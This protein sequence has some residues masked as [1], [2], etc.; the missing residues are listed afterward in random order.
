ML[1]ET[2]ELLVAKHG[3]T[4]DE[5]QAYI[6]KTLKRISNPDLPDTCERVGRSPLRK[7]S[8]HE[9]FIGPAAEL[10][11]R[12]HDAWDLLNAVGAALRFDVAEDAESVE[13]QALLASGGTAPPRSRRRSRG[14]SRRIRCSRTWSR[15]SNCDWPVSDAIDDDDEEASLGGRRG[16]RPEGARLPRQEGPGSMAG[17]PRTSRI[18]ASPA[19][20]RVR[21]CRRR[22]V[23]VGV[24]YLALH[25]RLDPRGA[26]HRIRDTTCSPRCSGSSA[27][28]SRSRRAALVRRRRSA[29][30]RRPAVVRAGGWCSAP[31]RRAVAVS[32]LAAVTNESRRHPE[33]STVRPPAAL[34]IAL[35]AVLFAVLTLHP[36]EAVSNPSRCRRV[37]EALGIGDPSR[38]GCSIVGVVPPV[39]MFVRRSCSGGGRSA[40]APR[41]AARRVARAPTNALA[42]SV[43]ALVLCC[44]RAARSAG[45]SSDARLTASITSA[46]SASCARPRPER[47][48]GAA[49]PL[50]MPRR[51][52][53]PGT[54]RSGTPRGPPPRPSAPFHRAAAT[55]DRPTPRELADTRE[56]TS[57]GDGN[58]G[59][60]SAG[61]IIA[62]MR[63]DLRHEVGSP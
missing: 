20:D 37:Y 53:S 24:V 16:R 17:R 30:P 43:A 5:Q 21:S 38:G 9:R 58:P 45:C 52:R 40:R 35:V 62:R 33:P 34:S 51:T 8:R 41:A 61:G 15:S 23:L 14:S 19:R 59:R 26:V 12:G 63:G 55:A 44:S 27:S 46:I 25:G 3:F 50:G 36:G 57:T 60:R 56:R 39:V 13:L 32:L 11:E 42:L 7:L 47:E 6:E 29:D 22:R 4:A 49:E 54:Q 28:S 18:R 1:A 48:R 2:K 31:A 10:A